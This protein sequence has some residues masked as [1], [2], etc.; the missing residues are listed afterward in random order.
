MDSYQTLFENTLEG[1][2]VEQ[3]ETDYGTLF[4]NILKNAFPVASTVKEAYDVVEPAVRPVVQ[5]PIT[6]M[7]GLIKLGQGGSL[8]DAA[9]GI[10]QGKTAGDYVREAIPD[11]Q[12]G[13]PLDTANKVGRA[14]L[15]ALTDMGIMSGPIGAVSGEGVKP[16]ININLDPT[17]PAEL[18]ALP[19]PFDAETTLTSPD[20]PS[21]PTVEAYSPEI[22][23]MSE[24]FAAKYGSNNH[25]KLQLNTWAHEWASDP[26]E[27][28]K[29][30]NDIVERNTN[31]K[32]TVGGWFPDKQVADMFKTEIKAKLSELIPTYQEEFDRSVKPE[33][34]G[35]T[36]ETGGVTIPDVKKG[37]EKFADKYDISGQYNDLQ[38]LKAEHFGDLAA[39]QY[40]DQLQVS[41]IF[42]GLSPA[43]DRALGY[44]AEGSPVPEPYLKDPRMSEVVSLIQH[45]SPAMM[46]ALPKYGEFMKA[47]ASELALHAPDFNERVSYAPHIL[48]YPLTK[49][50]ARINVATGQTPFTKMRILQN[51]ADALNAG[52]TEKFPSTSDE[53]K[54]YVGSVNKAIAQK[55]FANLISKMKTVNNEPFSYPKKVMNEEGKLVH[56]KRL[57]ETVRDGADISPL[58]K[59]VYLTPAIYD[60]LR[61]MKGI[62]KPNN[63]WR[64]YEQ[65]SA[66]VKKA[67]LGLSP[68]HYIT[69]AESSV[70]LGVN[71]IKLMKDVHNSFSVGG[72][73]ML[74]PKLT[75]DALKH[76]L[77]LAHSADIDTGVIQSLSE[78][79]DRAISLAI[80]DAKKRLINNPTYSKDLTLVKSMLK[81]AIKVEQVLD[82]ALWSAFQPAI[83]LQAYEHNVA[84]ALGNP[85]FKNIPVD[86]IKRQVSDVI[87]S[88]AGGQE[89]GLIFNNP[90]M[91]RG[92]K[93]AVLA[94]DWTT[95]NIRIPLALPAPGVKGFIG[96]RAYFRMALL[97]LGISE[98]GTM[99]NKKVQGESDWAR[100]QFGNDPGH[101]FD[102][103]LYRDAKGMSHYATINKGFVEPFRWLTA[104]FKEFAHKSNPV[105]QAVFEQMSGHSLTGYD[106]QFNR[107]TTVDKE[108]PYVHPEGR[109]KAVTNKL[110]PF[111]FGDSSLLGALPVSKALSITNLKNSLEKALYKQD[112]A[113][114]D[115]LKATAERNGI[116]SFKFN[117]IKKELQYEIKGRAKFE[118]KG[119]QTPGLDY[120][121]KMTGFKLKTL[122]EAGAAK[123][124]SLLDRLK[125]ERKTK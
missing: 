114:I 58:L 75:E 20:I 10:R 48:N 69:L 47:K 108:F 109:V 66:V 104:P 17:T 16:R 54:A 24:E 57:P 22:N 110:R 93:R 59:D 13:G 123:L 8:Q 83:K 36:P 81:P 19:R 29:A 90:D 74:N 120:I 55:Q 95:S 96:R 14:G 5:S 40:T 112:Q 23:Q 35:L 38:H 39:K 21:G 26:K 50:G 80:N 6:G 7:G 103:W 27:A 111:A 116:N 91:E 28:A 88:F 44:V 11:T 70:A 43:E 37:L 41:S 97:F 76:N 64:G 4:S 25:L 79:I 32:K 60:Q 62:E 100:G 15:G 63:F 86:I 124:Q 106:L 42:D 45:P 77:V 73:A 87:N 99:L 67:E 46:E 115:E 85:K 30:I 94:L 61:F 52:Y 9:E 33:E 34:S 2:P 1:K 51:K 98:M 113:T 105:L 117:R 68:F 118:Q 122:N 102:M 18:P 65:L 56:N 49:E 89:W 53:I 78:K 71:P 125:N 84:V 107:P 121:N 31:T 3:S 101:K 119:S 72:A 82:F 12:T 92:L